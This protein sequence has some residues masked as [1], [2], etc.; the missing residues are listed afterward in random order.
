MDEQDAQVGW[1]EAQWSRIRQAVSE[2]AHRARVAGSF[3]PLYGPL[4]SSTQVVPS[5]R[6]TIDGVVN[7]AFTAQMIEIS[8]NVALSQQQ[9][10]EEGLASAV[11]L[12]RRAANTVARMEDWIIFHGWVKQATNSLPATTA[13]SA[14]NPPFSSDLMDKFREIEHRVHNIMG[15]PRWPNR[16]H[17]P[18]KDIFA[19]APSVRGGEE[20]LPWETWELCEERLMRSDPGALGLLWGADYSWPD[21]LLSAELRTARTPELP[22]ISAE[23]MVS[24]IVAAIATLEADG[25]LAPFVC[26]LGTAAFVAAHRPVPQSLVLPKDR[27]EPLLGSQLLRSGVMDLPGQS[28]SD[29]QALGVVCSLAGDAMDLALAVDVAPQFLYVDQRARYVF[30]VVERFAPRIKQPKAIVRLEFTPPSGP[31]ARTPG[32]TSAETAQSHAA[33]AGSGDAQV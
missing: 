1:T 30:R 20:R 6:M 28:G 17:E 13:G 27:I 23:D 25:H 31:I 12:F 33:E 11:Q 21:N 24:S 3:L 9:A 32:G 29:Y 19:S 10:A 4:P 7:N 16:P 5:E 8:V 22:Q 2:E 15:P 26:V 14:D 18:P